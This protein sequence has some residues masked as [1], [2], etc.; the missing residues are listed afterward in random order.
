MGL[1]FGRLG[2]PDGGV[3]GGDA[4]GLPKGFPGGIPVF[5]RRCVGGF[6]GLIGILVRISDPRQWKRMSSNLANAIERR[7]IYLARPPCFFAILLQ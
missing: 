1:R 5:G 6:F 3:D 4:G 2:V 7:A